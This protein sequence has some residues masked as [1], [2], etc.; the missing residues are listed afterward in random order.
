MKLAEGQW[1]NGGKGKQESGWKRVEN[2]QR[3]SRGY[4]WVAGKE[5]DGLHIG[6]KEAV[7]NGGKQQKKVI[8]EREKYKKGG[9]NSNENRK[10]D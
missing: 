7:I 9:T 6:K 3:C 5:A 4:G 2:L 8:D 1:C 10:R